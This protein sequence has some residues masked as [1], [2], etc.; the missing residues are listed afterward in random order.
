MHFLNFSHLLNLLLDFQKHFKQTLAK[1]A[2]PISSFSETQKSKFIFIVRFLPFST[3]YKILWNIVLSRMTPYANYIIGE[4]QCDFRNYRSTVG[5]IFS[6]RQILEKKWEYNKD[7]CQLFMDFENACD[8][9]RRESFYD[10][11]IKFIVRLVRLIKTYLDATQS[12]ER[13]GN[14]FVL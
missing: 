4:Y 3:S 11:L 8:S 9:I 5:H 14:Y 6:I 13:I 1:S 10:I 12:K 2:R 7:V